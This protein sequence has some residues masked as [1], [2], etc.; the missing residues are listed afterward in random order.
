MDASI[1]SSELLSAIREGR[2]P[3]VA[4]LTSMP[5]WEHP[6]E[7]RG[8]ASPGVRREMNGTLAEIEQHE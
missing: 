8:G 6:L 1:S 4:A 5:S 2:S 7:R 3:L